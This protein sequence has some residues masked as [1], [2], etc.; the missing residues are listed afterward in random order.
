MSVATF[1]WF[2]LV[3]VLLSH[4]RIQTK[5]SRVQQHI[6]KAAGAVLIAL[7]VRVALARK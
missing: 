2:L 5:F 3:A 6:E 4:T 1:V 7:G